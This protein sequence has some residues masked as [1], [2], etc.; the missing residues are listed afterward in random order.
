MTKIAVI[1][2]IHSNLE[3]FKTILKEIKKIGTKKIYCCGDIV[4]YGSEPNEC[5]ELVRKNKIISV[6]GN[7]DIGCVNFQDKELFNQWGKVAIEWSNKI[8]SEENKRFL[9][10]LPE[11]I[12]AE[13]VYFVHGSPRD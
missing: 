11:H 6:K 12:E 7:H 1:A 3:A 8:L 9:L 2:D 13:G 10:K 5:V 4:G